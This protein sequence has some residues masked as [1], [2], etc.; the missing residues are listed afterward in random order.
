[1]NLHSIAE[2]AGRGSHTVF[3]C[4]IILLNAADSQFCMR[5]PR[6]RRASHQ[7]SSW[8]QRWLSS[9]C[10]RGETCLL[11]FPPDSPVA[12]FADHTDGL[13]LSE[14]HCESF[15]L[16][17][18]LNTENSFEEQEGKKLPSV[19]LDTALSRLKLLAVEHCLPGKGLLDYVHIFRQNPPKNIY[20]RHKYAD[21][22]QHQQ[23]ISRPFIRL[24]L[25]FFFFSHFDLMKT[26]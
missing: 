19:L 6:H 3:A 17:Q 21:R 11:H 15:P 12:K 25:S 4:E 2:G 16:C 22:H 20:Y 10:F 14:T 7:I 5:E 23:N 26:I 8:R 9:D 1:M 13:L 18:I 24:N